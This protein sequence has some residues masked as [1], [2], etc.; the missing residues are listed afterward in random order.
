MKL[1]R[2]HFARSDGYSGTIPGSYFS[3][4]YAEVRAKVLTA[5]KGR[6]KGKGGKIMKVRY[7][8]RPA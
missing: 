6:R 4:G 2:I 5:R 3:R 1:Y 8:V 7:Y